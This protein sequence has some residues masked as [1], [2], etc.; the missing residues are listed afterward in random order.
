MPT[1]T[2][3]GTAGTATTPAPQYRYRSGTSVSPWMS[4]DQL[5]EAALRGEVL[6]DS[7]IQQSGHAEWIPATNVRGLIFP[8]AQPAPEPIASEPIPTVGTA[9]RHPRFVTLRDLL[10]AYVNAEIEINL[11]DSKEFGSAQLVMVGGDHFEITLESSRS[12]VFIPYGRIRA[13]WALETSS[14]ATLNY[15]ESHKLSVELEKC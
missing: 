6:P 10:A 4:A 2:T 5:K 14:S 13:I 15:R 3:T 9:G 11:P 12:R 1:S 8:S 7:H